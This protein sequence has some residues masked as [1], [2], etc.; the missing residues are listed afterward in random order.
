MSALELSSASAFSITMSLGLLETLTGKKELQR[1][2]CHTG[3]PLEDRSG[4]A[5]DQHP[6]GDTA[7]GFEVS[8]GGR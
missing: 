8:L 2:T 1:E 7:S 6:R 5:A 3:Q 4:A